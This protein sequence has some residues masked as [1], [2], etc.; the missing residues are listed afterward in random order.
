VDV[1][2][3]DADLLS[4]GFVKV[5]FNLYTADQPNISAVPYIEGDL[6]IRE[7]LTEGGLL[8][9]SNYNVSTQIVD[10]NKRFQV[11]YV[12]VPGNVA[13]RGRNIDWSNYAEVKALLGFK[14]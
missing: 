8:L 4:T 9:F 3:I 11:R 13:A 5:Y 10:G 6:Y 7:V 1:E 12:I 2:A 14:N